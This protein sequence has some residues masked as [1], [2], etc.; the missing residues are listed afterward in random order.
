MEEYTKEQVTFEPIGRNIKPEHYG[1]S[2]ING[3]L[4]YSVY[5]AHSDIK[6][7]NFI[8]CNFMDFAKS[9]YAAMYMDSIKDKF[10]KRRLGKFLN[11]IFD[12][13]NTLAALIMIKAVS[14]EI[15]KNGNNFDEDNLI[16]NIVYQFLPNAGFYKV[17][18]NGRYVWKINE[19]RKFCK[20]IGKAFVLNYINN[21]FDKDS[22]W[23]W[24]K[25][26][27]YQNENGLWV[28]KSPK[29]KDKI[30][31]AL[32]PYIKNGGI[33]VEENLNNKFEAFIPL[34]IEKSLN[35]EDSF[36]LEKVEGDKKTYYVEGVA[37]T[38][39]ID[40]DDERM[41]EGFIK[42]MQEEAVGLP[43]FINKHRPDHIDETIGVI[44]K[45]GGN[46]KTFKISAKLENPEN[47]ELVKKF[48][49]KSKSLGLSYGFSVGGRVTKAFREYN[50]Q[51]KK[52]VI[53]LA[54]GQLH[55]VLLTN[56]PANK[57]TFARAVAKSLKGD[58][59][60]DR[61]DHN[62][63]IDKI[64]SIKHCTVLPV[65]EPPNESE[66]FKSVSELPDTAF[67]I[68]HHN[69]EIAR[70]Y[71][72]HYMNDGKLFIHKSLLL[73]SYKKAID[74]K[75]PAYVRNHLKT[76]IIMVG[77]KDMVD[78][79][80][81]IIKTVNDVNEMQDLFGDLR[82]EVKNLKDAALSVNGL[83]ISKEEKINMIKG[84]LESVSN[85]VSEILETIEIEEN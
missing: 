54:E 27:C 53:V 8:K 7:R 41:S 44:V 2:H 28:Y 33:F 64:Y 81:S 59:I 15:D 69:H 14:N 42:T 51:L 49:N 39:D 84:V 73:K 75:A 77:L 56:Q 16:N 62:L 68:N 19:K 34:N 32:E 18:D 48:I 65:G 5:K 85:K 6:W 70:D 66:I 57:N 22:V 35:G 1:F 76:H 58:V 30:L 71:A 13:K 21:G 74:G 72:H 26:N 63:K 61:V 82:K 40:Y 12:Q 55:H 80:E 3:K 46:S 31:E 17:I 47:N 50:E 37:S 20:T 38:T 36:I 11:S 83:K 29:L 25:K 45:S 24:V 60:E 4:I 78:N 23:K 10:R 52:D 67:P 9:F 79:Y 43:L